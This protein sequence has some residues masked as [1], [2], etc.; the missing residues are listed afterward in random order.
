MN[1]SFYKLFKIVIYSFFTINIFF[2][3]FPKET[4]SSK[5]TN[6]N[7]LTY[8][9][10]L[11]FFLK[12]NSTTYRSYIEYQINEKYKIRLIFREIDQNTDFDIR[13]YYKINKNSSIYIGENNENFSFNY[14]YKFYTNYPIS[15][16]STFIKHRDFIQ[17]NPAIKIELNEN[18]HI[19][20]GINNITKSPNPYL[21][22][23]FI[24]RF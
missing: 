18:L 20:Y 19:K 10:E 23:A 15:L 8:A 3:S 16:E 12:N 17:I 24:F 4:N 22:P 13:L 6:K 5:E 14:T 11:N 9:L 21:R 2:I 7:K 1:I